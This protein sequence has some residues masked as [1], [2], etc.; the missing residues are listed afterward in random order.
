LL[1][2]AGW[3]QADLIVCL[4]Q[5][6]LRWMRKYFPILRGKLGSYVVAPRD[7]D[8]EAFRQVRE[9]RRTPELGA[10]LRFLWIGRWARHKGPDTL[11]AFA[12]RRLALHK[13]DELT[14]A[15]CGV[16]DPAGVPGALAGSG[17][18]KVVPHYSRD[19]LPTLLGSHDVGLFTS[20]VEGWGLSLNEMLESGMPVYATDAGGAP[21]LS[22][23]LPGRVRAFP[24]GDSF[25]PRPGDGIAVDWDGFES[26]FNWNSIAREYVLL[27]ER[28]NVRATKG[29]AGRPE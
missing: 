11:I 10:P 16:E 24:P 27:I 2:L 5:L 23:M 19:M 7:A 29:R 14:I 13:R 18:I 9:R 12:R 17:R 15:G 22:V 1:V 8:R 26:R 21:D 3:L 4:G 28:G 25:D 6:E 20:R